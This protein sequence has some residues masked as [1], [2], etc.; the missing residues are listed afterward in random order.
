MACAPRRFA[1]AVYGV[2]GEGAMMVR[3]FLEHLAAG[4]FKATIGDGTSVTDNVHIDSVVDVHFLV[5]QKL[6]DDPGSRC[7]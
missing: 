4:Q 5:A 6:T 1:P 7:R 2:Q 3:D